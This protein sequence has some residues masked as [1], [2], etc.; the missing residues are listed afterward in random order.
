MSTSMQSPESS[1]MPKHGSTSP[2]SVGATLK[3]DTETDSLRLAWL[4]PATPEELALGEAWD[5]GARNEAQRLKERLSSIPFYA[6][7][8]K[9]LGDRYWLSLAGSYRGE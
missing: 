7:K 3:S 1:S 9:R 4:K 5:R 6:E 2:T 8:A